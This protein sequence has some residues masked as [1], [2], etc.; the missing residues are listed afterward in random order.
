MLPTI[1]TQ[2]IRSEHLDRPA[3]IYVRQSTAFQ[4]RENTASAARQYDLSRRA[5]D[6][7]WPEPSIQVI[8]QD[9]GISGASA[10]DREGF[11]QL[12]TQVGLGQVGAVFSLEASRLARS[13]SDWHRLLEICALTETLVIDEEGVYDPTQY[14]DRLLLGIMGTMSAAELHWLRSRL[15]GGQLEKARKGEFRMKP[16]IGL[17]Y[18]PVGQLVL[19]P[20][21]QIQHAVRLIFD[22]F[23]NSSSAMAVVKHFLANHLRFP[24]RIWSGASKGQVVWGPLKYARAIWVLHHPAYAGTYVYGRTKTAKKF[25]VEGTLEAKSRRRTV[26]PDDWPIVI[27]NH[28]PAYITVERFQQN[29]KRLDENRTF[30]DKDRRGAPREGAGLLQGI[31]RCGRCG[32][33]MSVRYRDRSNLVYYCAQLHNRLALPC[34]QSFRGDHVDAAVARAFL[35]AMHPAQLEVSMAAL[36]QLTERARRIDRQWQLARE[37]VRY[38]ADLAE[39]RFKAVD[40][41]NRLVARSLERDWNGKMTEV[42]RFD[43]ENLRRPNLSIRLVDPKERQRIL[44][45]AQ[46]LPRL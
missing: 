40:P 37:R 7:G 13:C 21:E 19:D 4:V 26:R 30:P 5:R 1:T 17:S 46:D 22:V 23:D 24:R 15:L 31:V 9:Q 12:M 11:R 14:G 18:D 20:D 28:H 44:A 43:R 25:V 29:Q 33:R 32:R 8:D 42:E 45:L 10:A 16:P 3:L 36:D 39:R 27:P 41:E 35:E 34:C 6:L 2:K 38:E